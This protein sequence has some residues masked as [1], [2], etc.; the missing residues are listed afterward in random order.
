MRDARRRPQ[1]G[2]P[3]QRPDSLARVSMRRRGN[4]RVARRQ[5]PPWYVLLWRGLCTVL[6]AC[7]VMG[8]AAGAV[9][10]S[11]HGWRRIVADPRLAVHQ[12]DVVGTQRTR[13]AEVLAYADA[14]LGS[15]MLQLDLDAVALRVRQ[16]PWIRRATIRRR[17]PDRLTIEVQE[18]VPTLL[19]SLGELYLAD[20]DGQ[21]FKSFSAGD[22]L[23]LPVVTGLDRDEAA[24]RL[25][26]TTERVREGIGLA[27][28][29]DNHPAELGAL[30]ELHWDQDL[31]WSVVVQGT[32]LASVRI[33]LGRQPLGRLPMAMA[34][35]RVCADRH[36][37]PTVVWADGVKNPD[38]VIVQL[39]SGLGPFERARGAARATGW[40]SAN[41]TEG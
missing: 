18:H 12:V 4:R 25:D 6:L 27:A 33:H 26:V 32:G 3:P 36:Q 10:G 5:G 7:L 29:V 9:W 11:V 16:H 40:R 24:R 35:L 15:P 21:L 37:S 34:T 30:D 13:V 2:V 17:F 39:H 1:R 14:P 22:G 8:G 23:V 20:E 28:A 19:V 41:G 31:G 38:R